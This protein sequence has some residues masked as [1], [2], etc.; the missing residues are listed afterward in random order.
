MAIEKKK[1]ASQFCV[2][3]GLLPKFHFSDLWHVIATGKGPCTT[4]SRGAPGP[5]ALT[6][7]AHGNHQCH[8]P[9]NL[10][11]LMAG[12]PC[13]PY[14]ARRRGTGAKS[15]Q[16]H[17]E[18]VYLEATAKFVGLTCR[19]LAGWFECAAGF[20]HH[21]HCPAA[22][23]HTTNFAHNFMEMLR[24]QDFHC[25]RRD[26]DLSRWVKA[27]RPCCVVLAIDARRM[28]AEILGRAMANLDAMEQERRRMPPE[29]IC[30]RQPPSS[31]SCWLEELVNQ[32]GTSKNAQ[33]QDMSS[34]SAW[35]R[36]ATWM[37]RRWQEEG[38][39]WAD[40]KPWTSLAKPGLRTQ[41]P[42]CQEL[43]DLA[44]LSTCYRLGLDP[45]RQEDLNLA[46]MGLTIDLSQ[47][48]AGQAWSRNCILPK[49]CPSSIMGKVDEDKILTPRELFLTYGWSKPILE[50]LSC[51]EAMDLV[52]NSIT[53]PICAAIT[54]SLGMA[55][56]PHPALSA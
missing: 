6:Q 15:I 1:H 19:P 25:A 22:K 5:L 3:M 30:S 26:M 16:S 45:R 17:P 20:G 32:A 48:P 18:Y 24:E 41:T 42:R 28:G 7:A 13:P 33:T 51:R 23:G 31:L 12:I 47:N 2:N 46:T 43:C 55:M 38:A 29:E 14:S 34:G 52:G 27:S 21:A 8:I 40:A 56:S 11:L 36:E 49:A 4:Y 35:K 53:L 9:Q 10:D 37:R 44:V 39:V 50:G 54:T